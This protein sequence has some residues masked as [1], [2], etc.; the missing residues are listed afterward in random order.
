MCMLFFVCLHLVKD[1]R[2][3]IRTINDYMVI[4]RLRPDIG[5]YTDKTCPNVVQDCI[6]HLCRMIT[7][8]YMVIIAPVSTSSH[9]EQSS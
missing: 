9:S 3:V 5:T 6:W 8:D 1:I 4:I 2:M 7:Q